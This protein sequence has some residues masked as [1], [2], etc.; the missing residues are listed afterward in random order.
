MK[1]LSITLA[2]IGALTLGALG[3]AQARDR[4]RGAYKQRPAAVHQRA[5][6]RKF[7]RAVDH[8]QAKQRGRIRQGIHS[9]ALNHKQVA[10]MRN[11]QRRIIKHKLHRANK[12]IWRMKGKHYR[13][14]PVHRKQRRFQQY[15]GQVHAPHGHVQHVYPVYQEAPSESLGLDIETE[16][17][18]FS[19]NKSG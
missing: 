16:E 17:F 19:V 5:A 3:T 7:Q 2:V 10:R 15:F 12:R 11:Q 9:G 18:R 8:R 6:P 14:A 4:D 1:N 13:H